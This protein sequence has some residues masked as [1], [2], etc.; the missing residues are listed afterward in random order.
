[1]CST[2]FLECGINGLYDYAHS[3]SRGTKLHRA[4]LSVWS[5]GF[6]RQPVLAKYQIALAVARRTQFATGTEPYQSVASLI[7]LRN[8]IAH[9]KEL[10]ETEPQRHRLEVRLN[11]K[12][13][14]NPARQDRREFLPDRC[15]S[16]DCGLWAVETAA[17][18]F[19]DFEQRMPRT[20][21]PVSF[22]GA[23]K[24]WLREVRA[25]RTNH[26]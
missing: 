1:M 8:A 16:S 2:S 6:D 3:P 18:F 24:A 23:I 7:D 11:G 26:R 13:T 21:Y 15:L 20:A 22:A 14:L 17:Q 19:L 4:L 25:V 5:E 10:I 12:Y 9:P